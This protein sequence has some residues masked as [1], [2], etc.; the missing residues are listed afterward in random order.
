MP[1]KAEAKAKDQFFTGFVTAVEESSI[2]VN[3]IVMGNNSTIKT[4]LVTGETRFEGGRP[5]VRSQVTVRYI[6]GEDGE[7]AVHVILRRSPK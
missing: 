4:F 6:T 1:K 2:T 3:R 5:E 7:R